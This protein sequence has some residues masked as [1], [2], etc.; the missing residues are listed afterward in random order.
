MTICKAVP[1]AGYRDEVLLMS[2]YSILYPLF[3]TCFVELQRNEYEKL[4]TL[5]QLSKLVRLALDVLRAQPSLNFTALSLINRI[6]DISIYHHAHHPWLLSHDS[7]RSQD[8]VQP[9]HHASSLQAHSA[10]GC[11]HD[12][13]T[14]H[15]SCST[16]ELQPPQ[17]G[18][19][20][21]QKQD[22][23]ASGSSVQLQVER[24]MNHNQSGQ[25]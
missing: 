18:G 17:L 15:V 5:Q 12:T 8:S 3:Q 7:N 9:S 6:V 14:L 10:G 11:Q 24:I 2:H 16:Q 4:Q 21:L 1:D 22:S 19:R 13:N 25:Y 20:S 23:N